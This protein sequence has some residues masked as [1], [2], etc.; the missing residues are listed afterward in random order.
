MIEEIAA[1]RRRQ[2]EVEGWTPEH[3]DKHR[4]Y[5]LAGAAGCYAMHTLAYPA[6]DPPQPW[7]WDKA[8]W[9]PSRISAA[10]GSRPLP[11]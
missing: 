8:W 6:G 11:C 3:D 9:K 5:A 4:D 7:P 1:E 2:I 10:T